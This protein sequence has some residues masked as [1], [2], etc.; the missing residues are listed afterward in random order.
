MVKVHTHG[1]KRVLAVS[2]WSPF[3][4]IYPLPVL[5]SE[6][7]SPNSNSLPLSFRIPLIPTALTGILGILIFVRHVREVGFE[8]T[9]PRF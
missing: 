8:P 9:H 7:F 3:Q 5:S 4:V 1:V 6:R 2:A